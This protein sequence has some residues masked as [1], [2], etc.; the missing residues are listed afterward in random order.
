MYRD[1]IKSLFEERFWLFQLK[2]SPFYSEWMMPF[3]PIVW[4]IML[5]I[6]LFMLVPT[7][8]ENRSSVAKVLSLGMALLF[9]GTMVYMYV[10]LGK[11]NQE[12]WEK[13]IFLR[14]VAQIL[15][16][17]YDVDA[18]MIGGIANTKLEATN[19]GTF[20]GSF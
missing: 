17:V 9:V 8:L 20:Y 18:N 2:Y 6:W 5:P 11:P 12:K 19:K 7:L 15:T 14:H 16:K 4:L 1:H 10:I 13:E 3:L